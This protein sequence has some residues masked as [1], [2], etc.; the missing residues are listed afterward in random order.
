MAE[1]VNV[2]EFFSQVYLV[3]FSPSLCAVAKRRFE[4]LG[5]T[6][7]R[8]VCQDARKFRL[9]DYEDDLP[10]DRTP[11]RSPAF[12]YFAQKRAEYGRANLI[13]MSYSL[14]MMVRYTSTDFTRRNLC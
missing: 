2:P 11:T 1:F 9:E 14:S 5:W 10:G 4:R 13:T 3:D 12:G 6:N 7:V 8:V